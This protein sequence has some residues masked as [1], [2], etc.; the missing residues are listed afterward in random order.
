MS[1]TTSAH[2]ILKGVS[3]MA[4]GQDLPPAFWELVERYRADLINQ[5]L[6]ILGQ[7]EDAEEVA[8]E[9][10]CEAFR[11]KEKLADVHSLGAWLRKI[12]RGNALNRLR[13]RR[14]DLR[15]ESRRQLEMRERQVT[16][17]GFSLLETRDLVAKAIETLP[18]ELRT[19]IVLHYW[20]DLTHEKIAERTGISPRTIRRQLHDAYLR[21]YDCLN[22]YLESETSHPANP[23]PPELEQNS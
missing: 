15:N 17:G 11:D 13:T 6:A 9:T 1:A 23:A 14:R 5:G 18:E 3:G 20:E 12:N 8:Q 7:L 19:V 10:F 4:D 22:R 16:T 2:Q 21:M